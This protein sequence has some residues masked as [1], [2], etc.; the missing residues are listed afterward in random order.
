MYCCVYLSIR[1]A[2]YCRR[3]GIV[4][5]LS[6]IFLLVLLLKNQIIPSKYNELRQ[7]KASRSSQDRNKEVCQRNKRFMQCTRQDQTITV[8]VFTMVFYQL[9]WMRQNIH[10]AF[11][12]T[13]LKRPH[14]RFRNLKR[15]KPPVRAFYALFAS[16][17]I[18]YR[19]GNYIRK[20]QIR[21]S[22]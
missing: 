20:S 15:A 17:W 10:R 18:L 2:I 6:F 14:R 19:I 7:G 21:K 16:L 8:T 12:S 22:H 5:M 13:K 3:S 11:T 9:F 4:M 1:Y